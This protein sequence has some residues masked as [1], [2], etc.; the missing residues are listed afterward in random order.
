[1]RAKHVCP[2]DGCTRLIDA[3]VR[4]CTEHASQR[5]W[6]A[7][8]SSGT[9][10]TGTAAHKARRLRILKRDPTCRLGYPGCTLT[11]TVLDHVVALGLG[12][13][14]TDSNCQGICHNCSLRKSSM[15]G[16]V[17]AGHDVSVS[18]RR[19]PESPSTTPTRLPRTIQTHA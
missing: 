13:A 19:G 4:R 15:E 10:R 2:V 1:M 8:T 16:H 17:A 9:S 11:S 3:G 5:G 6:G 12:G 18:I 14:D 7:R